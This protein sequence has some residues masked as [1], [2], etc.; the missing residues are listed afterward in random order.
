MLQNLPN[1]NM[2]LQAHM[3]ASQQLLAQAESSQSVVISSTNQVNS[4]L[5]S[6]EAESK[7]L[8]NQLDSE[9]KKKSELIT[10]QDNETQN[11]KLKIL[12]FETELNQLNQEVAQF[13]TKNAEL[14]KQIDYLKSI[15]GR[16]QRWV[17]E[18]QR[19]KEAKRIASQGN[20]QVG[21]VSV[22]RDAPDFNNR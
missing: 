8:Q 15:P 12:D 2:L 20:Y 6:L 11:L 18:G 5:V 3:R 10:N 13:L 7:D 9:A 16:N 17:M 21:Y 19:Q 14:K 4:S 1:Q 22:P